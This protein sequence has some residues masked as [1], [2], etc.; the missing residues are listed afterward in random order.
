[1]REQD[2][3]ARGI[4]A[5][6]ERGGEEIKDALSFIVFPLAVNTQLLGLLLI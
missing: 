4:G 5:K 3:K 6:G 1:M 2:R